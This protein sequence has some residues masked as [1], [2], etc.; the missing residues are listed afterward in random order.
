MGKLPGLG[1][2]KQDAGISMTVVVEVTVT[3]VGN[4]GEQSVSGQAGTRE[5]S[6]Q[7]FHKGENRHQP[8]RASIPNFRSIRA[9]KTL[10][11]FIM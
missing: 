7:I 4:I 11:G 9:S 3:T 10:A 8:E 2:D 5:T 6:Q 1:D